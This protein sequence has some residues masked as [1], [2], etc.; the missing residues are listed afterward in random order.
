M[1]I[2]NLLSQWFCKKEQPKS[3]PEPERKPAKFY[4]GEHFEVTVRNT[5]R[6][7]WTLNYGDPELTVNTWQDIRKQLDQANT[8]ILPGE[9]EYTSSITA[10]LPKWVSVH[11]NQAIESLN[12]EMLE[13]CLLNIKAII[14][15]LCREK[16]P[17]IE[18]SGFKESLAVLV[19]N[20][21]VTSAIAEHLYDLDD[22]SSLDISLSLTSAYM[23][24]AEKI[25]EDICVVDQ[26]LE[27]VQ[28]LSARAGETQ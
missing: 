24:L 6:T 14:E 21:H 2:F 23:E 7:W 16:C 27:R 4:T 17:E 3:E 25:L 18:V 9:Q 5:R 22:L 28:K 20:D 11:F 26:L 10:K 12:R 1:S 15:S 8:G 13:S 19:D